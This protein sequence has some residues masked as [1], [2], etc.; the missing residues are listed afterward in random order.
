MRLLLVLSGALLI[1]SCSSGKPQYIP[2]PKPLEP[3]PVVQT[4]TVPA[5]AEEEIVAKAPVDE[6]SFL[7]ILLKKGPPLE[8]IIPRSKEQVAAYKEGG[9]LNYYYFK[10][11]LL[12]TQKEFPAADVELMKAA[13]N[14][15]KVILQELG[16]SE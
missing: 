9:N 11:N 5:Q 14:Y 15:P 13:G 12:V 16:A 2:P 6:N 7:A 8:N 4:E 3:D 1:C 10:R